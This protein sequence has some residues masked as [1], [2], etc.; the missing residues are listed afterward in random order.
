M[1]GYVFLGAG[2]MLIALN[3]C[4][5]YGS[6]NISVWEIREVRGD[7]VFF[8]LMHVVQVRREFWG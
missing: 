1:G 8:V 6:D 2:T 5:G 4:G 3:I 7:G